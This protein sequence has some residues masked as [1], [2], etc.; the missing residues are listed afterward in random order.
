MKFRGF[1]KKNSSYPLETERKTKPCANHIT[2]MRGLGRFPEESVCF[3]PR[4]APLMLPALHQG[5]GL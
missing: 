1:N 2:E 5:L 3:W 4:F